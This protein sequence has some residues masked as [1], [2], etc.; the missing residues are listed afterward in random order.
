M[1]KSANEQQETV[2]QLQATQKR[3]GALSG[4]FGRSEDLR[5]SFQQAGAMLL[6]HLLNRMNSAAKTSQQREFL[7]DFQQPFLPLP[8]RNMR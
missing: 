4:F 7:L 2:D 8:V 3:A 6:L 1:G 5:S